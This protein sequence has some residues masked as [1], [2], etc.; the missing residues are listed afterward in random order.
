MDYKYYDLDDFLT[1]D[2]FV[3]WIKEPNYES[4]RFWRQWLARNPDKKALV[5]EASQIILSIAYEKEYKL[6]E[7]SR[8]EMINNILR[9][10]KHK[11]VYHQ[12]EYTSYTRIAAAVAFILVM[13]FAWWFNS[14]KTEVENISLAQIVPN[15]IVKSTQAGQKLSL[16]LP[17]GSKV[18]LNSEAK[19]SFSE[20]FNDSLRVVHVLRG[21][22]FF[23][24]V[25]N[26]K[27][28]FVVKTNGINTRV[29][30]TSFNVKFLSDQGLLDVALVTGKVQ[31]TK[32]DKVYNLN[33]SE[34]LHILNDKASKSNFDVRKIT[35][36]KDGIL[37]I[38][39]KTFKETMRILEKWYGVSIECP[40][41]RDGVYNGMFKNESLENVLMGLGF[42]TDFEYSIKDKKVI[43]K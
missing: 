21:E 10:G 14:V 27:Q 12:R 33:P 35:G 2:F 42:T 9:Q 36:W 34:K 17:D 20:K 3:K 32:D 24:V 22:V 28:P 8:N 40:T 39:N 43:L 15:K 7:E 16:T 30:G 4:N 11:H 29:L 13:G 37:V 18:K 23:D 6:D 26:A 25:K 38:E 1:D 41:E 19:I 31:I 5:S